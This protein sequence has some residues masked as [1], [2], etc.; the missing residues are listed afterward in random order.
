[1]DYI[2]ELLGKTVIFVVSG[3][4]YGGVFLTMVLESACIPLPSEIILPFTG[5]LVFTQ[6]FILWKASLIAAFGNVVGG[7]IAYNVGKYG[8]RPFIN[9]YGKLFFISELKLKKTEIFF[10]KYGEAAVFFGRMLPIV[11]T[12]ISLPAG[13]AKMDVYKMSVYTFLGSLPWCVLLIYGGKLLGENWV[14]LKEYFHNFHIVLGIGVFCF[15]ILL[16]ATFILRKK[17]NIHK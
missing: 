15:L 17:K 9:K 3:F 6:K 16:F 1:M 11:R 2:L 13:I 12:F 14:V 8:G 5:Y 10:A 7:L 4:G